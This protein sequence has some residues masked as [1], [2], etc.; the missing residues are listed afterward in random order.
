MCSSSL[1]VVVV[2]VI[3]VDRNGLYGYV[4]GNVVVA[5]DCIL[6]GMCSLVRWY[7]CY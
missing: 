3:L 7:G 6:Y 2:V 5:V 1:V 4:V